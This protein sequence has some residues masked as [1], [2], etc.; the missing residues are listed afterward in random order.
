M[1]NVALVVGGMIALFYFAQ[2]GYLP[3]FDPKSAAS[4]L[5]AIAI[6]GCV[7]VA[8]LTLVFI[9]PAGMI[10]G[11]VWKTYC[12]LTVAGPGA[13]AQPVSDALQKLRRPAFVR[14]V[15]LHGLAAYFTW[16]L[17][18]SCVTY[19]GRNFSWTLM[20]SSLSGVV[21]CAVL[22][23]INFRWVVKKG[24]AEQSEA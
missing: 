23:I 18:V 2:I 3:D 11:Q 21:A 12:Q 7:L 19:S 14:A 5:I 24:P 10:R 20:W 6:L 16:G 4:T 9:V 13:P 1:W 8:F 17:L 22:L 15:F